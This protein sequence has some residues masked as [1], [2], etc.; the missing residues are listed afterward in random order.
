MKNTDIPFTILVLAPFGS[1]SDA[2][3]HPVL[4][5]TDLLDLNKSIE[6]IKPS[7]SIPLPR[8]ICPDGGVE[9]CITEMKGFRPEQIVKNVGYLT[10]LDYAKAWVE[11]AFQDGHAHGEVLRGFKD[12]FMDLPVDL[13]AYAGADKPPTQSNKLG[14]IIDLVDMSHSDADSKPPAANEKD[15]RSQLESLIRITLERIFENDSFRSHEATWRGLE[16][17]LKQGNIKRSLGTLVKMVSI[18][19]D[20]FETVLT[21]CLREMIAEPPNLVLVDMAFNN[22]PYSIE[23][24]EKLEW[25]S[26]NLMAPTMAWVDAGVFNLQDWTQL[27]KLPRINH[28]LENGVFAK[29]RKL[30]DH[31]GAEWISLTCNR[32]LGRLPFGPGNRPKGVIFNEKQPCWLSPV[33]ASG[34]LVAR[35]VLQYGWPSRF[36]DYRSIHLSD[37]PLLEVAK[38]ASSTEMQLS[39]DRLHQFVEAGFSPLMGPIK[40]DVAFIPKETSVAGGSFQF[41]LFLSRIL[42]LLFRCQQ[43]P[44]LEN[45]NDDLGSAIQQAFALL[46]QK[47][48]QPVPDDLKIVAHDPDEQG[49]VPLSIELTPPAS[50]FPSRQKLAFEFRWSRREV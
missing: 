43:N 4:L 23:L 33:W 49:F 38:G 15:L 19:K 40:K 21:F 41:Q 31:P 5:D 30:R 35:S 28:H 22:T 34:A 6:S 2:D 14:K 45:A 3:T 47:T 1:S 39:E 7:C 48:G 10:R 20:S 18:D 36:A 16:S 42:G 11:K 29:W 25:F 17:L 32:F 9:L 13:T 50:I 37:L 26:E 27:V 24:F 44:D 12:Q 8:E 46:W